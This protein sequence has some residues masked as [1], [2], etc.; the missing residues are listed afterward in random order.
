MFH[1]SAGW[2]DRWCFVASRKFLKLYSITALHHSPLHF[3]SGELKWKDIIHILTVP[4]SYCINFRPVKLS[5]VKIS[6]FDTR[7]QRMLTCWFVTSNHVSLSAGHHPEPPWP[8]LPGLRPRA[9]LP[10]C[11]HCL[12]VQRAQGEDWPSFWQEAWGQPQGS[13]VRRRRHHHHGAWKTH[14]CWELLPVPPTG[15][16]NLLPCSWKTFWQLLYLVWKIKMSAVEGIYLKAAL[17]N[18]FQK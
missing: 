6:A 12:Q 5:R 15:W 10:H 11:S 1:I 17:I 14:V 13:Q 3:N 18:I 4:S 9:W 7:G 16:V 2:N 8:D